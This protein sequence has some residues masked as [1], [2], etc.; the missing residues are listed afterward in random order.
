[1]ERLFY[2]AIWAIVSAVILNPAVVSAETCSADLTTTAAPPPT[3]RS[4]ELYLK[5]LHSAVGPDVDLILL[6]DSLAEFWDTKML[7]PIS[8]VNLGMAGDKTQNVIWRLLSPRWSMLTPRNVF[9]MLGTNNLTVD[10]QPC[11]IIA[12][13]KTVIK[14]ART[15]W[16]LAKIILLEI[17][18]RGHDFLDFNNRRVAVNI[19]M[20]NIP[21]IKT[22][23][24]DDEITCGWRQGGWQ[25]CRNYQPGNVHFSAAGYEVILKRLKTVLFGTASSSRELSPEENNKGR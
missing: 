8:V 21:D 19:A 24:V 11:A 17:T 13:L 16:P 25:A 22:I 6:G 23:N 20:R 18:P 4:L 12:G 1:V 10:D 9:I 5:S 7:K 15:L 14:R 3:P 2:F